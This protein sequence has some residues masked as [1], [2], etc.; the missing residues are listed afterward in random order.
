[1]EPM[2][3]VQVGL[4]IVSFFLFLLPI[5]LRRTIVESEKSIQLWPWMIAKLTGYT[6]LKAHSRKQ[7]CLLNRG[8]E[9]PAS[10]V[11]TNFEFEGNLIGDIRISEG[12]PVKLNVRGD[13]RPAVVILRLDQTIENICWAAALAMFLQSVIRLFT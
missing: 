5:R 1:M 4:I 10:G 3:W 9:L 13:E 7:F 11:D 6:N 8:V 12:G 2:Q